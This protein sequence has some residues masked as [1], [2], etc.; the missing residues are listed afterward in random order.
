[1]APRFGVSGSFPVAPAFEKTWLNHQ[2]AG[3][4]GGLM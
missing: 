4:S 1:M 3:D 2:W